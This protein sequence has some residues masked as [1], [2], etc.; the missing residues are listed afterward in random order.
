[1]NCGSP[2]RSTISS[3]SILIILAFV[4]VAS[5]TGLDFSGVGRTFGS[6]EEE[7]SLILFLTMLH[8]MFWMTWCRLGVP[9]KIFIL[10]FGWLLIIC[11]Y[12]YSDLYMCQNP[13]TSA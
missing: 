2:V 10:L 13:N 1:M 5:T 11:Y 7:S 9:I 8:R 3:S 12:L 6:E 4:G